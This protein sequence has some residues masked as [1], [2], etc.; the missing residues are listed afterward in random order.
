MFESVLPR[1]D[2]SRC[3]PH[4]CTMRSES[5]VENQ[6]KPDNIEKRRSS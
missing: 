1:S 4:S 6:I 2:S 3:V 5:P